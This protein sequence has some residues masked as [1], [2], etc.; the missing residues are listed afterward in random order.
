[1]TTQNTETIY[2]DDSSQFNEKENFYIVR[3]YYHTKDYG[4]PIYMHSHSFY[5]INIITDGCGYHY[6]NDKPFPANSGSVYVIPPNI[7]HGYYTEDNDNFSIFHIILSKKFMTKYKNELE[8]LNGYDTFFNFEPTLR[9]I[10]QES[11]FLVINEDEFQSFRTNFDELSTLSKNHDI[12][13]VI[14]SIG[15]TIYLISQF[16]TMLQKKH[17]NIMQNQSTKHLN[18]NILNIV[19]ILGYIEKNY[20]SKLT[21][22]SIAKHFHISRSTLI[23]QFEMYTNQTISNFILKTRLHSARDKLIVTDDSISVIAQDCGFFDS[24]HFTKYFKLEEG[25]TPMEYRQINEEKRAILRKNH[26]VF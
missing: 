8:A 10:Q 11:A 14:A 9:S 18:F 21:I 16:C 15:K 1:M 23:K 4:F 19:Y 17:E 12:N 25:V 2:Y 13:S 3:A 26:N 22:D 20:S 5:E 24:S 6:I 7:L